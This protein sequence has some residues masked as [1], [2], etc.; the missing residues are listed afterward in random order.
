LFLKINCAVALVMGM[1]GVSSRLS[2]RLEG[3]STKASLGA[4]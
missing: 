1:E 2:L 4:E 3:L